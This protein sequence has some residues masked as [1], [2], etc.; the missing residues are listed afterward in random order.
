[1]HT[2]RVKSCHGYSVTEIFRGAQGRKRNNKN[3]QEQRREEERRDMEG[4]SAELMTRI[5]GACIMEKKH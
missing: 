3:E 2:R 4:V 5:Q 1:M